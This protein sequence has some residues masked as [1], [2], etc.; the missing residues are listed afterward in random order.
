MEN[1]IKMDDLGVPLFLETPIYIYIY[2][3]IHIHMSNP[4]SLSSRHHSRDFFASNEHRRSYTLE[5]TNFDGST[6]AG[7]EHR[8]G[9]QKPTPTEG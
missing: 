8:G 4:T 2:I 9:E 3:S 7:V 1:P 6:G 5:V